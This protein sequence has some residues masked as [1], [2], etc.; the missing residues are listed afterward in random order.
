MRSAA[1]PLL[2]TALTLGGCAP[3]ASSEQAAVA[4]RGGG[5]AEA[6][7]PAARRGPKEVTVGRD[8]LELR[9]DDLGDR[10]TIPEG[11]SLAADDKLVE[12][13]RTRTDLRHE[14][15]REDLIDWI[16]RHEGLHFV[17]TSPDRS[18]V[19]T[20]G[21]VEAP[22][23]MTALEALRDQAA[24]RRE[25][26]AG[27]EVAVEPVRIQK[28]GVEGA[29]DVSW[30]SGPRTGVLRLFVRGAA[31]VVVGVNAPGH[32]KEPPPEVTRALDRLRFGPPPRQAE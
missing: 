23:G 7:P 1:C 30:R 26:L 16:R 3:A 25:R 8:G 5:G 19:V 20:L 6:A 15:D 13:T 10:Y 29:E 22:K 14:A 32:W 9:I 27:F 18:I 12:W 31:V 21:V 24:K 17:A 11:W 28:D 4:P 2:V